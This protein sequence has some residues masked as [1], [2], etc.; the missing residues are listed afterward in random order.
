MIPGRN[1][2]GRIVVMYKDE[3]DGRVRDLGRFLDFNN[4]SMSCNSKVDR[5][6]THKEQPILRR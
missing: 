6:I 4:M 3:E 1:V 5:F 2:R